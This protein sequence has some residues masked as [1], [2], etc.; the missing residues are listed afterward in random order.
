MLKKHKKIWKTLNYIEQL[1]ILASTVTG[2]VSISP[3]ACLVDIPV[4]STSSAVELKICIKTTQ[5]RKNYKSINKKKKKKHDK[6]VSLAKTKLTMIAVLISKAL[7]ESY[8]S[9][10]RFVLINNVLKEYDD[11]KEEIKNSR[12]SLVNPGF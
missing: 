1:F 12:N 7:I 11:M 9:H 5:E 3:F 8:I 2:C 4:G 6:I 10:D